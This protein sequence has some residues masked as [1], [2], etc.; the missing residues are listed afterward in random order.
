MWSP[1][2]PATW[3]SAPSLQPSLPLQP[4]RNCPARRVQ[5]RR[6][7]LAGPCA[8][9]DTAY[10]PAH[11]VFL[12][13]VGNGPI[14]GVF[15]NSAGTPVSTGFAVMDGS[16]GW[17]HFPRA[18][19]SPHVNIGAGGFLVSWH[20]NIGP[21]N[22]VFARVV[23]VDTPGFLTSGI[24]QVSDGQ[25]GGTWWETGPA[26]AY[27][28]TSHRFLV[29]WRTIQYGIQGRFVDANGTPIGGVMALE[30]PGGSRDPA[31][32]WNAATDEFGLISTGWSSTSAL[33]AFRRIRAADGS[34][35][36]RTSFG[37]SAGTFASAIDVNAANQYV[38]AWA[39]HPGT[40]SAVFD[41]NGTQL[42]SNFVTGRFGHDQSLGMAYNRNSGTFLAVGSDGGSLEV[43]AAEM[44]SD[45]EPNTVA[46]IIT[47]GARRGSNYPMVSARTNTSQWHVAYQRDFGTAASQFV[48][49]ST[50]GGGSPGVPAPPPPAPGPTPGPTLGCTMPD[51]F[52][53]HRRRYLRQRRMGARRLGRRTPGGPAP[54]G[55]TTAAPAPGWTCVNGGWL[56]PATG[57]TGG[58]GGCTTPDPFGAIGGGTCIGGGWVPRPDRRRHDR[59]LHHG[60][61]SSRVDMRQR[62]LAAPR[63]RWDG[64]S[65]Q[66]HDPRASF[67]M[68]VRQWRLA[69]SRA[70]GTAGSTCTTRAIP[71]P[72]WAVEPASAA[73]GR[74]AGPGASSGG[75]TSAQP[76]AGWA[77]A[78]GGWLPP[79][80]GPGRVQLHDR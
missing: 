49:T 50:T 2:S 65:Q 51:P 28:T 57:G 24:Q 80:A 8:G 67:G 21:V 44:K 16:L 26:M 76:A 69:T 19:Y 55:C 14:Y 36:A 48:A 74:R 43:A 29:A 75:C 20:H 10:D 47:D 33:A 58:T 62:R 34:V 12:V 73:A 18:E 35:S 39:L 17:G 60:G 22:Y 64:R 11:D 42:T 63:R 41:Q 38:L 30:N 52:A 40:M 23:S 32:A 15:V 4:S 77:C 70:G 25:Q 46:Q 7:R 53:S 61:A 31:V 56:P 68:D 3:S 66:L 5:C 9:T 27:S 79:G 59:W 6:W 45:G 71:S 37:F 1:A 54:G 13:V 72:R 78:N